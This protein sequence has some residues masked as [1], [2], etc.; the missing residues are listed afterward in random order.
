MTDERVAEIERIESSLPVT[1][2]GVRYTPGMALYRAR[3]KPC[4]GTVAITRYEGGH[5]VEV[6]GH[7]RRF[8]YSDGWL[9]QVEECCSTLEAAVEA[10]ARSTQ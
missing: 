3:V 4:C 8:G 7:A 10:A 9:V 5:T 2:D 6:D 1:K